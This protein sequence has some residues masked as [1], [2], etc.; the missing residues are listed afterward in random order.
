M[1]KQNV[2]LSKTIISNKASNNITPKAFNNLAK[3]KKNYNP[4]EIKS[5]YNDLF[6]SIPK[7]GKNSHSFIIDQSF[8]TKTQENL[9]LD[10]RVK[11]LLDANNQ[12]EQEYQNT[13][14]PPAENPLYPNGSFLIAGDPELQQ[15]F[16][17]MGTTY[18]MQQ[19]VKRAISNNDGENSLYYTLRKIEG[20]PLDFSQLN[21][22]SIDDLNSIDT[23]SPLESFNNFNIP[24]LT[25][26][27]DEIFQNYRYY[28][29]SVRCY[30]I[31]FLFY[32][33]SN[34]T[35]GPVFY[36]PSNS[37]IDFPTINNTY[38]DGTFT[39]IN[40]GSSQY[41]F[42]QAQDPNLGCR[43]QYIF[44]E[45]EGDPISY[46][47][48]DLYLK[49]GE[50]KTISFARAQ[51]FGGETTLSKVGIPSPFW[52]PYDSNKV[53]DAYIEYATPGFAGNN[54]YGFPQPQTRIWG[55]ERLY[56]GILNV[57]GV[58]EIKEYSPEPAEE[59]YKLLNCPVP[60]DRMLK[61]LSTPIFN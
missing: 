31:P 25:I 21:Y 44:N 18:Y 51:N 58:V 38:S 23:G 27:N 59:N 33:P 60:Q 20:L 3:S 49:P 61:Y 30:G 57:E 16:Q 17:G 13:L 39:T 6:Y 15:E 52:D 53:Y 22:L 11:A 8:D 41:Y 36:Y 35:A 54:S 50:S 9:I 19:G 46:E 42:T 45:F 14:Q 12:K 2:N 56:D 1:A 26:T 4:E 5:L 7:T 40:Q 32:A 24:K 48:K 37:T 28:N 10:Q 34:T 43:I 55:Y 47:I 29:V